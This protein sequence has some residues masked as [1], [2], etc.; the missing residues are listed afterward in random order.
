[1]PPLRQRQSDILALAGYFMNYFNTKFGK[2][3]KKLSPQAR[4]VLLSHP[5][6]GNVRELRNLIERVVL[7]EDGAVIE[8]KHLVGM[9]SFSLHETSSSHIQLPEHG[10][11]LEELE[12]NLIKQALEITH[13]NKTRAAKLLNMSPPTF[14]Y[15]LEK[16][17]L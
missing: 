8:K 15:R 11:D 6:K 7:A 5:W 17:G 12:K 10:V 4:D 9:T 2:D 1:M 14:Y 13:G 3:F 16:Y